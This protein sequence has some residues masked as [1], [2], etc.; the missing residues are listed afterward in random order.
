MFRNKSDLVYSR[1][2]KRLFLIV[3]LL[4]LFV[5][6]ATVSATAAG[7]SLSFDGNNDYVLIDETGIVM[8]GTGWK[9]SM[10]F[11]LWVKPIGTGFCTAND[12]AA[13]DSIFGDRPRWWGLSHGVV[14]GQPRLWAWNYDGNY[15]KIGIPY[16]ENE[17]VHIAW[18]HSGG[19]LSA[20]KNGV[21]IGSVPSGT[22]N[23][24]STGAQPKMQIGAIINNAERNWSFHGEIDELRIFAL[25]LTQGQIQST[26][27]T[28]LTGSETGLRAYYKMSDGSGTVLT[29]DSI[30]SFSGT[31]LD[32]GGIVAPDGNPPLWVTSNAFDKPLA[33]DLSLSLNED[34]PTGVTLIGQ[35]VP[36]STLTYTTSDP[37]H[38]TIS[39]TGPNK[40]YTPDSNYFGSDSF[41]YQV[42]D[43][44]NAS[45]PATV[46]I[47]VNAVNDAPVVNNQ[48]ISTNEDENKLIT[49]TGSD[50]EGQT[51]TYTVLSQPSHGSLSGTP[52][53]LTYIPTPNYFGSDS[54]TFKGNDGQADSNI[55][56]ISI[57]VNSV[58]DVPVADNKII[59]TPM[60][61]SVP[62]TLSGSD[63]EN[64]PLTYTVTSSPTHGSL[65]GSVPNLTFNPTPG[66]SGSDSFTYT[67]TDPQL[68][69]SLPATVTINITSGNQA[70]IADNQSVTTDEDVN[71]SITLT[72]SDPEMQ[73]IT[74]LIVSQPTH[75][76][77]TG[78]PPNVIYDPDLN[79]FGPDSFTFK[80]NDG[81]V[82]SN[83]ATVSITVNPQNDAPTANSFS[84]QT[85][86]N[87]S[88]SA[89]LSGSDVDNDPLT[90][91]VVSSPLHGSLSGTAPS[92]VYTPATDY[93]GSDSFTYRSNDGLL[94]S[95]LA[96]V[97]I[98]VSSGN[99]PPI[100]EPQDIVL[101]E[102]TTI[103]ITLIASDPEGAPLTYSFLHP[104]TNGS[105][106]GTAPNMT[107]DPYD[108]YFGTDYFI[109]RV[110][111]GVQWSQA[112]TV[113]ITVNPIND[114]PRATAQSVQTPKNVYL[115]IQLTGSDVDGD[116]LSF[117]I[118]TFPQNGSLGTINPLTNI[119]RY[120]PN[121]NYFGPDFFRFNA[122]DG[123]LTSASPASVSITVTNDVVNLPPIATDDEY[124]AFRNTT[125]TI[126]A[127]GVITNDSDP[128]GDPLTA[129]VVSGISGLILNS[130]GS[131]TYNPPINTVGD[132]SFTYHISDGTNQSNVATVTIHIIIPN[133]VYLPFI[134]K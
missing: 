62:I 120:T 18:V 114:A 78:T 116:P 23:Q 32:G 123:T 42:W 64:S 82:D 43:G 19:T 95:A 129:N 12:A 117:S 105:L 96:T 37:P 4:S 58:N 124:I 46:S 115:D 94:N 44:P 88:V 31:L 101:N 127:P 80:I 16:T 7:W 38:G 28:E 20:Y 53:S 45:S 91:T 122:S 56:T 5:P 110:S 92:L 97:T 27:F 11:S 9:D 2:L 22:T 65:S 52:P 134:K 76:L 112:A 47:T 133:K 131:F 107:Y 84:I 6:Q 36:G 108:N 128:N 103:P 50:V 102:D 63:V 74:F 66:Y 13:C 30:N 86:V 59:N 70:P 35:G 100:A 14:D 25:G 85:E 17:W 104:T 132:V 26:L 51:I 10:S 111:D 79:Y 72:G 33:S 81:V 87:T 83:I 73:S 34:T 3:F 29:D 40:T 77:L 130:N 90:F 125:L 8:G 24:P 68:A 126:V 57:T 113:N 39:G 21:L 75:G 48:S 118:H 15:D 55:G 99:L 71:K 61:T 109:F 1:L 119:V 93:S 89:P 106:L 49:L 54:F 60:N 121:S 41:T 69:T 98:S 67:V